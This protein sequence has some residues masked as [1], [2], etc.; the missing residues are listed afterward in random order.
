MLD[1]FINRGLCHTGLTSNLADIIACNKPR[2]RR[3]LHILRSPTTSHNNLQVEVAH[4]PTD[5][6]GQTH[7]L[8]FTI[9]REPEARNPYCS[10]DV[11]FNTLSTYR[12][13][14]GLR[15]HRSSVSSR[16]TAW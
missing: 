6:S 9:C 10:A 15:D 13:Y 11:S 1:P 4:S 2:H 7:H 8:R 12:R 3:S 14:Q 5:N 16:E